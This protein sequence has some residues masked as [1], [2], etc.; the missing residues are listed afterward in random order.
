MTKQLHSTQTTTLS[1]Y[2]FFFLFS[3][4]TL[5]QGTLAITGNS[6]SVLTGSV[7]SPAVNNNTDFGNVEIGS[8]KAHTFVLDNIASTTG[9][10][11]F[12]LTSIEI[13]IIGSSD[14]TPSNANLGN[15]KGNDTPLNHIITFAPSSSGNKSATVTVTFT[16]GTNSPYIFTIQ[17]NGITPTP[18]IEIED[19]GNTVIA[20]GGNFDFGTIT[21]GSSNTKT[22]TIKNI[23][24]GSTTLNL[25]GTPIVD[26][27]GDSEFTITAQPSGT[28]I[29]GG[30]NLTFTV[31]YNPLVIGGPH[32]A[33]ISIANDDPDDSENPYIINLQG[34]SDNI[35]Y[36]PTTSG[37]D[38]NVSPISSGITQAFEMIYG[39]DDYL[40]ITEKSGNV[41]KIDPVNGGAKVNMLDI[42]SLVTHDHSQNGLLG[43]AIHPDLY[44]DV[45]TSTNNYVY[46]AYS[47]F[48]GSLKVRIAR[49]AYIYNGGNGYLDSGSAVTV[50]EGFEGSNTGHSAGRLVIGPPNVPVADQKLYYSIGDQ[51][52]NR[53]ANACNEIR[54]QYLPTSPSDYSDYEGKII[55]MNLDGSIPSDNPTLNGVQSHV[56]TFGHRNAQGLIFGSD[57]T[58]YSSEHGDKVDDELNIIEAGKNYGWPLISGYNDDLGYGYCNWSAYPANCGS[59]NQNTCPGPYIDEATSYASISADF[60]EPIGT[61]NST[62]TVEPTG[63]YLTWP[64]VAPSSID[65]YEAGLIPDWDKSILVPMLKGNKILRAKLNVTVDALE[66]QVYEEFHSAS[67]TRYRDIAMDPD[68]ITI[69]TVTDGGAVERLKFVG[70]TLSI[71]NFKK[72][73]YAFALIPNPASDHFKL[74][75]KNNM[76]ISKL[77]I[78]IIDM[79]GRIVKQLKDIGNNSS[80]SASTFSNGLYFVKIE[81]ENK[82]EIAVKKLMIKH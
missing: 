69:Y 35:T 80:I 54:A 20:T 36:I 53:N 2:V 11:E 6:N 48:S 13:T 57:G 25:T 37:P 60:N 4:T 22:F 79:Q 51:E 55:R 71:E 81:D 70:T 14:F 34:L 28:S 39:P 18:E 30:N 27:S 44:T 46:L 23:S 10:P 68:G 21:P 24:N 82:K 64:T 29:L 16:N 7:N 74:H 50:L 47:Y 75:F 77:N 12:E 33:T 15:L 40:W 9:N 72:S 76:N 41:V 59:Y 43:M 56:Y 73:E 66:S 42:T 58:L 78:Q 61:Y 49:Y 67:G 26:I 17:G 8:N 45:T 19:S 5:A 38:W 31:K 65:I 1:I 63:G 52:K 3:I 32:T 62:V